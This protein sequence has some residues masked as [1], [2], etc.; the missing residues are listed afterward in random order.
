MVFPKVTW[1]EF[2]WVS[3]GEAY[4]HHPCREAGFGVMGVNGISPCVKGVVEGVRPV[5]NGGGF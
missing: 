5:A 4:S 1:E 2:Y 3:L